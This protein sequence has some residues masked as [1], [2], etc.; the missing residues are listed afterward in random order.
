M[1]R[2]IHVR[3]QAFKFVFKDKE[4]NLELYENFMKMAKQ[5]PCPDCHEEN[6]IT[7]IPHENGE[8]ICNEC[9]CYF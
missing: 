4:P 1:R 7:R 8:F 3:Q 6:D 2:K 9:C 5:V